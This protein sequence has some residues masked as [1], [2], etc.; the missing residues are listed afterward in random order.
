MISCLDGRASSLTLEITSLYGP[1]NDGGAGYHRRCRQGC[2]KA[3]ENKSVSGE[4]VW[5]QEYV[6][7][8]NIFTHQ[9]CSR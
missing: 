2:K 4:C 5:G 1:K 6:L 8:P 3:A 9:S 7:Q